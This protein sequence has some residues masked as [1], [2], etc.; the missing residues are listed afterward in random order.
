MKNWKTTLIGFLAAFWILAQ[1]II[2]NGD[3]CIERDWKPLMTS[4][5]VAAFGYFVKDKGVT[6]IGED[7][8]READ[9]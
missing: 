4:A 3:F 8:K 6:G 2:T 7:A 5:I 1:P 9:L